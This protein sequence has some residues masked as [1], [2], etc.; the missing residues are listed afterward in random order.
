MQISDKVF[1]VSGAGNG[2]G[3]Q[4]AL[5]LAQRGARIAAV[6]VDEA[7]LV[8]TADLIT[9]ARASVSTHPVDITNADAVAALPADVLKVHNSIDGLV[10]IAGVIHRF[11][12]FTDLSVTDLDRIMAVNFTGMVTMCRTFLPVLLARP[13]ANVTN[14]SSLSALLPFASQTLYSASKGAVKQFSEGLYAELCDTKVHV[15][16]VFPGNVSTN[17]TG[18]SGVEMLDAGGRKVRSVTPEAAAAKIVD[19]IANDRFRVLIGTDARVLDILSRISA[20]RT[21]RLVAKQ[22]KSVL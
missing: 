3:R 12:P 4:V 21:T 19:G 9:S 22:I 2:M 5:A 16:T 17:L 11:A 1:V 18:N 14:M 6:D 13:E 7:G 15:V 20:K 8:R 10:N